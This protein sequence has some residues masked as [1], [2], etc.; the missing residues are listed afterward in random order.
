M[1]SSC[2]EV[3]RD[4]A[5]VWRIVICHHK[6]SVVVAV[7]HHIVV[8]KALKEGLEAL[9]ALALVEQFRS[10]CSSR[11]SDKNPTAILALATVKVV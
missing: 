9:L 5:V 3:Y 8:L 2:V 1:A 11:A 4:K 6:G 7:K 10:R